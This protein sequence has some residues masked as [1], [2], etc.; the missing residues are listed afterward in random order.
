MQTGFDRLAVAR[1]MEQDV[2]SATPNTR[3]DVI[4]SIMIEGFGAVPIVD[5]QRRLVGIVSEYD[6]L[7]SLAQ[8]HTWSDLSAKDI[9]TFNPYSVR[10]ETNMG[11]LIHVLLASNLIHVPVV[12]ADN[13]LIG[14]VARRDILRA[15]LN[16]GGNDWPD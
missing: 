7:A 10:P 15:Y 13:R 6:L 5:E 11:T 8:R 2:R 9:V 1:F 16:H 14:I 3:A 12:E 4:A